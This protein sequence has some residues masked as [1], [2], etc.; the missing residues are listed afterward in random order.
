MA[1][2]ARRYPVGVSPATM[3]NVA[4]VLALGAIVYF[5]PGGGDAA[6]LISAIFSTAILAAFV[7]F[8]VRFYRERRMDIMLLDD[9][10]RAVLYGALGVIVLAMA[11][12]PRLI[13]TGGGLILWLV[14]VAGSVYG[15]YRV[16]RQHREYG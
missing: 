10:W 7:M 4:I 9:R 16:W 15:L 11:A 5:V 2:R 12:R 1:E 13:T 3:R 8:A 14:A 6:S